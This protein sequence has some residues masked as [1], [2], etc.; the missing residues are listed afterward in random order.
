[1]GFTGTKARCCR[2]GLRVDR[3]GP[4]HPGPASAPQ[5]QELTGDKAYDSKSD[6]AHLAALGEALGLHPRRPRPGRP[7]KS[8][9]DR[10]QIERKFAEGKRFHGLRRARYW[11]LAKVTI[12]TRLGAMVVNFKRGV[13]LLKL[14][15]PAFSWANVA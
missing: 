5:A 14:R 8:W 10:P 7:R 9:R 1:M 12:Q 4:A 11:D 6:R 2:R 13:T 15:S 3:A